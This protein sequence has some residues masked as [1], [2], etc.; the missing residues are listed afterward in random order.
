MEDPQNFM[1]YYC[2]EI[3][4]LA[5][6]SWLGPNYQITAQVNCE[7]GGEAQNLTETTT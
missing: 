3:I 4:A 6:Q 2:S 5:A 7:P 1:N